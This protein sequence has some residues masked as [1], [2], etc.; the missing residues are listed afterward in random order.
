MLLNCLTNA[1][2]LEVFAQNGEGALAEPCSFMRRKR[3]AVHCCP[4]TNEFDSRIAHHSTT[5]DDPKT[6]P[7]HFSR[8]TRPECQSPLRAKSAQM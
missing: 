8:P 1:P 4:V 3:G 7:L 2:A 6:L 5:V